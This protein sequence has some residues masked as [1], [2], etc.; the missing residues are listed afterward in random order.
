MKRRL[1][2]R[3]YKLYCDRVRIIGM[4]LRNLIESKK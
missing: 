3:D 1:G 2:I 4:K